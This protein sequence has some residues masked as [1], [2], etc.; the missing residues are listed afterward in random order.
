VAALGDL[1]EVRPEAGEA[2]GL[3]AL[4]DDHVAHVNALLRA[5]A[6]HQCLMRVAGAKTSGQGGGVR[7]PTPQD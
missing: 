7:G 5:P 2:A 3:A 4:P 1:V 6:F